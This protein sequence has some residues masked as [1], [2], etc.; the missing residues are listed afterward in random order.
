MTTNTKFAAP[1]SVVEIGGQTF[2]FRAGLTA[3]MEL[4]ELY[5]KY[6]GRDDMFT[7]GERDPDG[8][9]EA[10][11]PRRFRMSENIA[12]EYFAVFCAGH[13]NGGPAPTLDEW[14]DFIAAAHPIKVMEIWGA[15]NELLLQADE[16]YW[17]REEGDANSVLKSQS[18]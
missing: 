6:T 17:N 13:T 2:K 4:A 7:V 8:D 12:P 11:P 9:P 16:G 15:C 10:E 14:Q 18:E 5:G 1:E 3:Y